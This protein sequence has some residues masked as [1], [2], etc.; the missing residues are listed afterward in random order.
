[1]AEKCCF[2][3]LASIMNGFTHPTHI[4]VNGN[5]TSANIKVE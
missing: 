4:F 1:M 5:Q 2:E 3:V